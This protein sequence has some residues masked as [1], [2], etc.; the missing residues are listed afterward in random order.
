[1]SEDK[2]LDKHNNLIEDIVN[3]NDPQKLSNLISLFNVSQQKKNIVRASKYSDILDNIS[4]E[5]LT[6]FDNNP[7]MFSNKDLLEWVDTLQKTLEKTGKETS[8]ISSITA[9]LIIQQNNV[10]IGEQPK[11]SQESKEKILDVIKAIM[12]KQ[13]NDIIVESENSNNGN[14]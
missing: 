9:P 13:N 5:M 12:G 4:N 10:N 8:D 6:R 7:N 11:L 14:E 2:S 3:E 1:M